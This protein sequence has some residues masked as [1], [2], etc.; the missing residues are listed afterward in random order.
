MVG[1]RAGI[2]TDFVRGPRW[3][4][5]AAMT[6]NGYIAV[7]VIPGSFDALSFFDFIAESV[8]LPQ[9]PLRGLSLSDP[10]QLPQM[11]PYSPGADACVLILDNCRIHQNAMLQQ[12]VNDAG[13]HGTQPRLLLLVLPSP[14]STPSADAAD[15]QDERAFQD[16]HVRSETAQD[17]H[18]HE[19]HDE[20]ED[21]SIES[22]LPLP[23]LE[24]VAMDVDVDASSPQPDP[25]PDRE[26]GRRAE[27]AGDGDGA[28]VHVASVALLAERRLSERAGRGGPD[29][30]LPTRPPDPEHAR[31]WMFDQ[32]PPL[33]RFVR[34]FFVL[35][36]AM[37]SLSLSPSVNS[38]L[39]S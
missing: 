14:A 10:S 31:T 28:H 32:R 20:N 12:S 19:T 35:C 18:K 1:E 4:V 6:P 33:L 21:P 23:L 36:Y 2:E 11:N 16:A 24:E 3:S 39:S 15:A 8:V 25:R 34:L 22:P 7:K 30:P 17:E 26:E 9:L 27:A 13:T 29:S 5:G 38:V 37:L